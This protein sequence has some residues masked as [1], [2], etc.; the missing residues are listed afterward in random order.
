M[1]VLYYTDEKVDLAS[2]R[3]YVHNAFPVLPW[4]HWM[5]MAVVA[6]G[7]TLILTQRKE[8]STYA[9]VTLAITVFVGLFLLDGTVFGR[10]DSEELQFSPLDI[11]AEY[12]RLLECPIGMRI[13]M[14]F[15]VAA[16]IPF[17]VALSEFLCSTQ[18]IRAKRCLG[19]VVVTSFGLSL[20]IE[21]LQLLLKVGLFEIMDI[22]LNSSGAVLGTTI[23]LFIRKKICR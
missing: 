16:F 14:V 9:T 12:R 7:V 18:S 11:Q 1:R 23:A 22:V 3:I 13:L 15:N 6:L 5:V 20:L 19:S 8:W 2:F 10:L 21:C 4:W 17:G